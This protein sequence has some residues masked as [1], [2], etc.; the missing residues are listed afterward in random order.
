M[1]D[2]SLLI[3]LIFNGVQFGL[4]LFLIAA[5][6]TLIFGV[7]NFV[8]LAHGSFI[9]IG[10]Y[11][12]AVMQ[13]YFESWLVAICAAM[14]VA[15]LLA[16]LLEATIIRRLY[17]RD[18]LEQVLCT[19]GLLL[20]FNE[21]VVMIWG[22]EPVFLSLPDT[23]G[24]SVNL[25]PGLS[26]PS[27]RLA[28]SAIAILVGISLWFLV[29]RTRFG[30]LIRAG[31]ERRTTIEVLGV[32]ISVLFAAV[33]VL[34]SLMAAL[35][36]ALLGPVLA[37]QTGMG[38]PLLILALAIVIVGGAG[39]IGGTFI[40][41]MVLGIADTL[42]RTFL[43]LLLGAGAGRSVAAMTVYLLM[44]LTLIVKPGGLTGSNKP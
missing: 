30:M 17:D 14:A 13:G 10:A 34:A 21:A 9:M 12:F 31:A 6:V 16:L 37:V 33:F 25:L 3:E 35:A 23:F 7:M 40:A 8:N 38:D 1:M 22:R 4:M 36:G 42:A 29:T 11:L 5:G 20:I 27:Y 15:A 18:H 44:A 2:W 39:S 43:P 28:I 24:G 41:A 32:N 26:Y 19:F